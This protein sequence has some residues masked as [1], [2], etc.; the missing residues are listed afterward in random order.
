[1]KIAKSEILFVL[2]AFCLFSCKKDEDNENRQDKFFNLVDLQLD[3]Q[4]LSYHYKSTSLTPEI[5]LKFSSPMDRQTVQSGIKLGNNIEDITL[6]YQ[7]SNGDSTVL[8]TPSKQLAYLKLYNLSISSELTSV[9]KVSFDGP[10]QVKIV[11]GIDSSDKFPKI[12]DEELL[13]KVQS[14]TFKYFWDFGHPTSGMARERNTSADIVTTGGTGFGIMSII[15]AIERGF[16]TRA[17]GTQRLNKIVTFLETA[18]RF[19]GAWPHWLNGA[20]GKVQ[21]FSA[22]DNGGD[23]VETSFLIQGLLAFRQYLNPGDN[24]EK[25][26]I[27]RINVLWNE[28]EWDWY[29]KGG[30]DVLYWHW[31]PDKAWI[32]N[33]KIEGYNEALITY[34]LAAASPTHSVPSS[35]YTKGWA[36]NGSIK[37]GKEFYGI[38]LPLGEDYGGPLFFTHYSF[39]GLDP[40]N[41]KDTYGDY[42]KQNVNH[43]LI[44]HA[45]CTANPKKYAGYSDESWGLTAS[46]SQNGY[47]AHSPTND[48]GVITPTAALSSMPYT[49][50]NSLKALKFFYY[51][52]GDKVW[53]DYGFYDAFNLS[54]PWIANSYLAID[55]GPIIVMIE[56]Y[57]SQLLWNLFMSAPEVPAAKLKLGFTN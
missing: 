4:P 16:I 53:G 23:L 56:N 17:E 54:E 29:T 33:H 32:M 14:Q 35:V 43:S 8:A 34:F 41:L 37:N 7:F 39:L 57:R 2:L 15:V 40:R 49:P 55:Q 47:S 31:S 50:E 13:T 46:D 22:N 1:M 42:W 19:H 6:N 24:I 52:L 26:L 3:G 12:T 9:S 30:E 21:P 45:Y 27:D 5:L 20:T 51:K 38:Q 36:R 18:E 48:L 28:V 44:N 10:V 11:T 25:D